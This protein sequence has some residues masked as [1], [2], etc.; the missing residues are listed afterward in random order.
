[1]QMKPFATKWKVAPPTGP[2]ADHQAIYD[3][4][5]GLSGS[6]FGKAYMSA[7]AQDHYKALDAFT[8][9]AQSTQDAKFKAAVLKGKTVVARHTTMADSLQ[10]KM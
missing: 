1:M 4:L 5:N 6:D 3:R 9:E 10:N 7:M 2:D 8:S